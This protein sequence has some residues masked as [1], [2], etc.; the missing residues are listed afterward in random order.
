MVNRLYIIEA[1]ENTNLIHLQTKEDSPHSVLWL[2]GEVQVQG[3]GGRSAEHSL[4]SPA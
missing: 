1:T 3:T 4:Y 2:L